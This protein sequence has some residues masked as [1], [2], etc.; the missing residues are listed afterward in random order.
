MYEAANVDSIG[1]AHDLTMGVKPFCMNALDSEGVANRCDR[2][3][4][5]DEED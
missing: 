2:V 1:C 5:I 4:D 3:E